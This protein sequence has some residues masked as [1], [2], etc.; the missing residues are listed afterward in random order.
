MLKK[1]FGKR[2]GDKSDA[3]DNAEIAAREHYK[4]CELRAAPQREGNVWRVAGSIVRTTAAGE[5]G[6]PQM[7]VRA[8]TCASRDDAVAISLRKARQIVDEQD[9][10]A[11][12]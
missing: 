12:R 4:N 8:D 5:E 11:A 3:A 6:E 10:M 7:F 2:A 1:L 9:T